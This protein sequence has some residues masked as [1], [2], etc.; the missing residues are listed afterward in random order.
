MYVN[1]PS[2]D[3]RVYDS[4]P[5]PLRDGLKDTIRN[6]SAQEMRDLS[7]E[8]P[9]AEKYLARRDREIAVHENL[10]GIGNNL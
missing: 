8:I 6:W 2:F 5:K 1:D 4:L 3:M 9:D 10:Y 7:Q